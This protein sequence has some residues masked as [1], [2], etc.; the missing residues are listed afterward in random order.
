MEILTDQELSDLCLYLSTASYIYY[1]VATNFF[2]DLWSTGCRP[3]ELV[4][5]SL[6]SYVS[7][8]QIEL[9][10]LK[11]NN[12]RTFIESELSSSLVFAIQNSIAPYDGLSLRQLESVL[13]KIIPVLQVQTIDK[14]AIAYMFRY[15]RVKEMFAAGMSA[16]L[17]TAAFGWSSEAYSLLY[18]A[19]VLYRNSDL[20]PFLYNY[21]INNDSTVIIDSDGSY[22]LSE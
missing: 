22:I 10:P 1:P 7:S 20:P 8:S 5:I 3:A 18:S 21:I 9:T 13:Y 4:D 17:V 15:N 11:G 6:W 2:F 19:Q 16:S 12:T 14:N